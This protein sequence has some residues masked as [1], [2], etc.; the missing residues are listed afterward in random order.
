ME[1]PT[2]AKADNIIRPGDFIRQ[3]DGTIVKWSRDGR[4][5]YRVWENEDGSP[6]TLTKI[7]SRIAMALTRGV[8]LANEQ[9]VKAMELAREKEGTLTIPIPAKPGSG[10][11]AVQ[12]VLEP[13]QQATPSEPAQPSASSSEE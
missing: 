9:T 6:G 7:S 13:S 12:P 1:E 5:W 10:S 3:Q 11:A 8:A 2:R 4:T